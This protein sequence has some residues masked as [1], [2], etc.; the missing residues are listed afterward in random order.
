VW[1]FYVGGDGESREAEA[2]PPQNIFNF[3]VL[4]RLPAICF[5]CDNNAY[6]HSNLNIPT[7]YTIIKQPFQ[8]TV[9]LWWRWRELNCK[10]GKLSI[11]ARLNKIQ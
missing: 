3:S 5:F 10:R 1:L 8:M 7:I 11:S 4:Y 2:S 9:L 6:N